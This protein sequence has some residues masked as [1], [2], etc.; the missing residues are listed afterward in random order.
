MVILVKIKGK[1]GYL[2]QTLHEWTLCVKEILENELGEPIEIMVEDT[3]NELPSLIIND[4]YVGS[5]LPGEE[6]YLIE[7]IKYTVKS[8]RYKQRNS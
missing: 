1:P 6:G 7:I 3:E 4:T 8:L 2:R 5:G